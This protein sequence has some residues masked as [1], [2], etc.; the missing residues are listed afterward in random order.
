M[1]TGDGGAT[2][3]AVET[4]PPK[5]KRVVVFD[6]VTELVADGMKR[7]AAFAQTADE[8]GMTAQGASQAFYA[9]RKHRIA[10]VTEGEDP[11]LAI[12]AA[13]DE[14]DDAIAHAR[15]VVASAVMQ[16]ERLREDAAKYAELRKL[17]K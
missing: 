3:G 2:N 13:L 8:L 1:I 17:I 14:V 6:R 7:P 9:E 15:L 4:D 10:A 11:Q 5:L 16:Y 12:M